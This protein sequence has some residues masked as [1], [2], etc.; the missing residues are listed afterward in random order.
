MTKENLMTRISAEGPIGLLHL[1]NK[2]LSSGKSHPKPGLEQVPRHS[3]FFV[4]IVP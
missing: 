1:Q 4:G 2:Y 3:Y